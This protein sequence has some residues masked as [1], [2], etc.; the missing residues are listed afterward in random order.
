MTEDERRDAVELALAAGISSMRLAMISL[1]MPSARIEEIT[2]KARDFRSMT[3]SK[4]I[5][6]VT[7]EA[8]VAGQLKHRKNN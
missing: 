3:H 1:G 6:D 5:L 4:I 7:A 8:S 2:G